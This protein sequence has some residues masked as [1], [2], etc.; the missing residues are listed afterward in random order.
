M[1]VQVILLESYI[2]PLKLIRNT[3][4]KTF[5]IYQFTYNYIILKKKNNK[6]N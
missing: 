6:F 4:R 5:I 2:P 1:L 3:I